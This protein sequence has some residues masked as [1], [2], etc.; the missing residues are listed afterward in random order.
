[1]TSPPIIINNPEHGFL[2]I[3]EE[4]DDKC[5]RKHHVQLGGGSGAALH[6]YKDG[7]W[8]LWAK[9]NDKGS[10][11]IQEGTGPINIVS[12]GDINIEAKGDIS[13]RGKNIIM[14]TTGSDGDVVV[15]HIGADHRVGSGADAGVAADNIVRR[16]DGYGLRHGPVEGSEDDRVGRERELTVGVIHRDGDAARSLGDRDGHGGGR[17]SGGRAAAAA[18]GDGEQRDEKGAT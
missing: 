16:G 8:C 1:M 12:D 14:E 13:M 4:T 11:L 2:E 18:G 9:S 17:R 10:T 3:G 5:L 6:I 15:T 7:G